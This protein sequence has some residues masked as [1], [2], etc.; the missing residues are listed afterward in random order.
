MMLTDCIHVTTTTELARIM[1][2]APYVQN[3]LDFEKVSKNLHNVKEEWPQ[4]PVPL[5]NLMV[6]C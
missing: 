5:Q 6:C 3:N 2:V 4:L 1:L